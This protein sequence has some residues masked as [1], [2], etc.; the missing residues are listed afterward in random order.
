MFSSR[1]AGRSYLNNVGVAATK[2]S[3]VLT[4]RNTFGYSQCIV[5]GPQISCIATS[6]YTGINPINFSTK[7]I[8]RI[9]E[10]V[11]PVYLD[12]RDIVDCLLN[13]MEE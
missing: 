8:F 13:V 3:S 4:A 2:L 7:N 12:L 6:T 10:L 5:I 1:I 11:T 9:R